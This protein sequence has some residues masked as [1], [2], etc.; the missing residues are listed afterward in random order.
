ARVV[1]A[2]SRDRRLNP[3]LASVNRYGVPV[4]S[5]IVQAA[6]VACVTILS[7]VAVPGIFGAIVR[8][9]DLAVEIYSVMQ[10]GTAVVWLC[11]VVQLF[12]LVLWLLYWHKHRL[13]LSKRARMLQRM[14]LSGI[15][16]A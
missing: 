11:S 7:F 14:L 10:A 1:I 9:A 4:R 2:G 5:I 8:P 12:V 6:I 13:T 3:L 16:L 15:S